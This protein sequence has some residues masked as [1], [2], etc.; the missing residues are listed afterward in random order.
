MS[1]SVRRRNLVASLKIRQRTGILVALA[2]LFSNANPALT[3][4]ERSQPVNIQPNTAIGTSNYAAGANTNSTATANTS[5]S[6]TANTNSTAT[7]NTNSTATANTNNTAAANTDSTA[8][9][10]TNKTATGTPTNTASNTNNEKHLTVDVDAVRRSLD[11]QTCFRQANTKNLEIISAQSSMTVAQANIVIAKAIPNPTYSMTYG[12]GPAWRFIVAGNNQ[13]V[14]WTEEILVAGRRTKRINVAKAN[15]VQQAFQLEAVRFNVHNR[16]RRAYT[17]LAAAAAYA[18]LIDSQSDIAQQLLDI[19]TK[20]F[21]AGKAPGSEVVQARL[22]VM[23]FQPQRNQARGRLIQDSAN[24]AQ[25][26]GETPR[27]IELIDAQRTGLF[28]LSAT[29]D[30]I[31][32]DASLRLPELSQL[33]PAAW[34]QRLDLKVA[35]QQAYTNKQALVLAKTARIPD[36]VIG[37][38]YMWTN[39]KKYQL[40]YFNPTGIIAD[41]PQNKVPMQPGYLVS[42]SEEMPIF[43]QY[44]GPIKQAA[45]KLDQQEKQ[46]ELL[47]SQIAANI[48]TSYT[49]LAAAR[50]NIFKYQKNLLPAAANVSRL[51]R[52]GYELGKTELA[53][54]IL[55][56]QNYQQLRASYFDAVVAY[57]NAWADMEQAVGVPLAP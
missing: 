33:V 44:R 38:D 3:A 26:L 9:A 19:S 40:N 21:D 57:Q 20:R 47:Q 14:G 32:P 34:R 23:Q 51:T 11:L 43:N 49:A 16:V 52:R 31:T 12:F 39:Y 55:A 37:F 25:L 41:I 6:A 54:A 1:R 50:N 46:N 7:A 53:T 27:R 29:A 13:Q 56:Q 5:Y 42:I 48:V 30:S 2:T 45:A 24:L 28:K 18:E 15:Q 36:P 4:T 10:N 35:L 17:E 8:T 22:A